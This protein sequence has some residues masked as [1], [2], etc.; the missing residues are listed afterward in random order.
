[1]VMILASIGLNWWHVIVSRWQ[2]WDDVLATPAL[3]TRNNILN[4]VAQTFGSCQCV[5]QIMS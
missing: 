2:R 1:M 4:I 5:D 3:I